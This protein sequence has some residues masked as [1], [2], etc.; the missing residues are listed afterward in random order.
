VSAPDSLQFLGSGVLSLASLHAAEPA[1]AYRVYVGTYTGGAAGSKGVYSF[2]F[3]PAHVEAG[4]D[5]LHS[6]AIGPG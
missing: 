2:T 4:A 1:A 5:T 3:D 6:T